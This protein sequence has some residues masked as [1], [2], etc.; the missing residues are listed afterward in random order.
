MAHRSDYRKAAK[1]PRK[2]VV[3]LPRPGGHLPK[4]GPKQKRKMDERRSR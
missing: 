4:G 3:E 1:A 2:K